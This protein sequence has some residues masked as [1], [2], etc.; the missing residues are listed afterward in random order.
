[1]VR[2]ALKPSLRDASCCKVPVANGGAGWR[3]TCF[4]SRLSTRK[5]PARIVSTAR[6]ASASLGR[7]NFCSRLPSKRLRRALNDASEGVVNWPSMV[8]YSCDRKASIS[9]SRSQIRRSATDCT[10]PAERAPWSLRQSTGDRVKPT[11]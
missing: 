10:R 2:S 4:R 6:L 11:R 9:F 8:Q 5:L 3:W 1:M 7:S